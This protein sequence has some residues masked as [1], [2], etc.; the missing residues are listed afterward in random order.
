[1]SELGNSAL[2]DVPPS[3]E[4][5]FGPLQPLYS[6]GDPKRCQLCHGF[7]AVIRFRADGWEETFNPCPECG[8]TSSEWAKIKK[9][10]P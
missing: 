7:G 6:G 1:M 2:F 3:A 4:P 10:Q 8:R 5:E 9:A